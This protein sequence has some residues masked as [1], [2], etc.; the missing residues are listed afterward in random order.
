MTNDQSIAVAVAVIS[1]I[2]LVQAAYGCDTLHNFNV[3]EAIQRGAVP[4]ILLPA[5]R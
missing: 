1:G 3:Q 4:G 2:V 5:W